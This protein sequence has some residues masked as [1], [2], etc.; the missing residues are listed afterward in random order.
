VPDVE[1]VL[2]PGPVAV[3]GAAPPALELAQG[4]GVLDDLGGLGG[5]VDAA[6]LA[7]VERSGD[8]LVIAMKTG[9]EIG[10]AVAVVWQAYIVSLPLA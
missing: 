9:A 10:A 5:G 1:V 4:V 8:L 2:E 6:V 7:A 3:A